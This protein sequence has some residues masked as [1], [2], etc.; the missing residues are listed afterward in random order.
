MLAEFP[1]GVDQAGAQAV[2][3]RAAL[4]GGDEVDI[5][6][7]QLTAIGQPAERPAHLGISS[8]HFPAERLLG[9]ANEIFEFRLQVI[10]QALLVT[11]FF[12]FTG[13]VDREGH[14]QAGAKHSLGPK[15]VP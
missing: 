4:G 7:L 12:F 9:Q 14:G 11:P 5:T 1:E 6:F 13:L 15:Q 3:V 8:F 2:N 10:G